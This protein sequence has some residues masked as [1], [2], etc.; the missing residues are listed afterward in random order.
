MPVSFLN[1]AAG[2]RSATLLK[3]RLL[4]RCFLVSFTKFR[5]TSFFT[6]TR[7]L[8]LFLIF[9]YWDSVLLL[10]KF[11]IIWQMF[12]LVRHYYHCKKMKFS[13]K[14]FF[15]KCDQIHRSHLLK[16]SLMEN[17]IFRWAYPDLWFRPP[18]FGTKRSPLASG[19]RAFL[20][21]AELNFL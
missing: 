8:L 15:G 12:Q 14:D 19:M 13:I 16:K 20:A 4:H 17:F 2:L 11:N 21:L 3:K 5:R 9:R 10:W 6:D 18:P 7:W 1:K